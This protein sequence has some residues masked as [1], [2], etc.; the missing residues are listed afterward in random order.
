MIDLIKILI[1]NRDTFDTF[2]SNLNISNLGDNYLVCLLLAN[3]LAYIFLFLAIKVVLW[4]LNF[5][6]KKPSF[7]N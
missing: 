7:I 5:V 1:I 4:A 2:L 3:I 6:F